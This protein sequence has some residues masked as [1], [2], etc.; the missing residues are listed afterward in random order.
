[1]WEYLVTYPKIVEI[2]PMV[3]S[4]PCYFLKETAPE[5]VAYS[6]KLLGWVKFGDSFDLGFNP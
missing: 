6:S 3:G 2:V 5:L 4:V 1:M